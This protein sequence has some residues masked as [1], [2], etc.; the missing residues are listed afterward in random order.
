VAAIPLNPTGVWKIDTS[1]TQIGFSVTHLGISTVHGLFAEYSG[2]A[3][4]GPDPDAT[5]VEVTASTGSINTGNTWRDGHL[6]GAD[7]FDSEHFPEMTFRSTSIVPAGDRYTLEGDLTVKDT[8]KRISFDLKF[9]G[10]GVFPVD[11][12]THA[13]FVATTTVRRSEFGIG[14]GIPVAS[15]EVEIR[16]DAQLVAPGEN[17]AG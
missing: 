11:E 3:N 6:V 1:H 13:G 15:D 10:V 16:I 5:S 8:T 9:N 17:V 2:H 4:I 14:Y 7:F 12:S